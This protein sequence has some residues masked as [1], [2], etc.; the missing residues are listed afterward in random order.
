MALDPEQEQLLIDK[1][2]TTN[3]L[4]QV[5]QVAKNLPQD[6]A[7]KILKYSL[8][9]GDAPILVANNLHAYETDIVDQIDWD[10]VL[11]Q[12]PKTYEFLNN[13]LHMAA[14]RDQQNVATLSNLENSW[15]SWHD[16]KEGGKGVMQAAAGFGQG[17]MDFGAALRQNAD[18]TFAAS[19]TPEEVAARNNE[20]GRQAMGAAGQ[21]IS[22]LFGNIA[23]YFAPDKPK[24]YASKAQEYT[25]AVL[26]QAPQLA[27]QIALAY[28]T[29]GV[30]ATAFMGSQIAGSEYLKLRGEGIEPAR[31]FGASMGDAALQAPLESIGLNK[32]M[33][34]LPAGKLKV[35]EIMESGLTEGITE[36]IQQYPESAAEIWARHPEYTPEQ[37]GAQFMQDFAETTQEGIY[38]GLVA[39]P[40]GFLGGAVKVAMEKK[41]AEAYVQNI[42]QLVDMVSDSP[43]LKIS[44]ETIEKHL[45]EVTEGENVCVDPEAMVLFQSE[46]PRLAEEL[47]VSETET[48]EALATGA[49]VEIP[50]GKYVTVAATHPEVQDALKEF[51]SGDEEGITMHRVNEQR[52]TK[53]IAEAS[54][55]VEQQQNEVRQESDKIFQS[56][57]DA[58]MPKNVARD[59]LTLLVSNAYTQSDNPVQFLRDKAPQVRRQKQGSVPGALHQYAGTQALTADRLNLQE[60]QKLEAAGEDVGAAG[61]IRQKTGWHKGQDNKWRFEIDDSKAKMVD[62]SGL[63]DMEEQATKLY[64][65]ANKAKDPAKAA[66]LRAKGDEVLAEYTS[67][68]PTK[69]SRVLDHP[70][71]Y[72]AYPAIANTK[73]VF[74]DLPKGNQGAYRPAI[75]TI[76]LN[77]NLTADEMKETL[78]HEVQHVIQSYEQFAPGGNPTMFDDIDQTDNELERLQGELDSI[79]NEHPESRTQ[80]ERAWELEAK[81]EEER[82]DAEE[83]E[84]DT[85]YDSVYNG[86]GEWGKR[87][88]QKEDELKQ[89]AETGSVLTAFSQYQRLHGEIEARDTARRANMTAD[90][91]QAIPPETRADAIILYRGREFAYSPGAKDSQDIN[92]FQNEGNPKGSIHWGDDGRA[93]ITLMEGADASTV[94]HE[95][96]GH[97][98][99]QNLLDQGA[100]DTAPEWMKKDRKTVL[101]YVGIENWET[102]TREEKTAAH[103]KMAE[104]A[105]TYILEGKSPSQALASVFQRFAEWLTAVYQQIRRADLDLKPEIREVFDRMLASQDEI[106]HMELIKDYHRRMPQEILSTLSEKQIAWLDKSLDKVREKSKDILRGRVLKRFTA[107]QKAEIKAEMERVR[108]EIEEETAKEPIYLAMEELRKQSGGGNPRNVANEYVRGL[109]NAS[110]NIL[111]NIIADQYG[112]T[113]A[114][115]MMKKI[116]DSKDWKNEVKARIDQHIQNTFGDIYERKNLLRQ[117]A[118]QAMFNEEGATLLA[119]E[120]QILQEKL[121]KVITR[122]EQRREVIRQRDAAKTLAAESIAKVSLDRAM[123]VT[124]YIAA[125]RR[126]AERGKA[127]WIKGDYVAAQKEKE[128]QLH[129]HA[130]VMASLNARREFER[131]NRYLKRQRTVDKLTWVS[132]TDWF[133]AA[134]L[135]RRFGFVRKDY[136]PSKKMESLGQYI[137]RQKTEN[138]DMIRIADWL[139]TYEDQVY[140]SRTLSLNEYRDVE[141]ALRNIKK[142][143]KA[144]VNS[145]GFVQISD[146]PV[147]EVAATL[148]NLADV[149]VKNVQTDKIER[150][151]RPPGYMTGLKKISQQLL[152]LDGYK[153]FGLWDH[154]FS[155]RHMR[156]KTIK[157]NC[158]TR[159]WIRLRKPGQLNILRRSGRI[160]RIRIKLYILKNGM[161]RLLKTPY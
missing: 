83:N 48:Q 94:I 108:P 64:R 57:T 120:D 82:T 51:I 79:I 58:G 31:A 33:K 107:E 96:V 87:L 21:G 144:G 121:G 22:N 95:L 150:E 77:K 9:S 54:K 110:Q 112:F 35:R 62:W 114:D 109:T 161:T 84:L 67:K 40:F 105:E 156:P 136:D 29:G 123:R 46:N 18:D 135:L 160:M 131:I 73:I 15:L 86:T 103:E 41:Q 53:D 43:L 92:Y 126:A 76:E 8:A 134:D 127:A 93:I 70:A 118:E 149:N 75:N 25:H 139:A 47:G 155:N 153:D 106:A 10:N 6:Q 125:E 104:A 133:Q 4:G 124:T 130:M 100:L 55:E 2:S 152:K 154:T 63:K 59:A 42:D 13:P 81:P 138:P 1:Y 102:A 157:A 38:Q 5:M 142:I 151:N 27:A 69:L 115:H 85:I 20:F 147:G 19:H 12:S 26:Q 119:I 91:R 24:R 23:D 7:A 45:D 159:C 34:K 56:W 11:Q 101:E 66:E 129:N 111:F 36:W 143:A 128:I 122:E 146:K 80:I 50:V 98:F 30:G 137:T 49:M 116:S 145:D 44:P 72:A 148:Y 52:N 39:A 17:V 140:N 132:E 28:F 32:I 60:A 3:P 113:S 14:V 89:M 68:Q 88:A 37:R 141:N 74:S 71:L 97:Y 65:Q 90:E 158:A 78:L 99:T 61:S 117:E 16:L